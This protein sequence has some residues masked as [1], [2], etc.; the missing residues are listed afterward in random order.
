MGVL[1]MNNREREMWIDSDEGLYG[2]WKSSRLSKAKF[3]K[4]N[5][6]EIDRVINNVQGGK[7]PA[8]YL[9]YGG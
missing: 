9:R 4:E 2:W 6:E 7:K 1:T 5:R 3:I 8:H